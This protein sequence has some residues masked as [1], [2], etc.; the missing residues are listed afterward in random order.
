MA[1]PR[2]I[3]LSALTALPERFYPVVSPG[4]VIDCCFLVCP[5]EAT[6]VAHLGDIHV[7]RV[8]DHQ[9]SAGY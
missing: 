5:N 8:D 3:T 2:E 6:Q 1:R 7:N 4:A 9:I